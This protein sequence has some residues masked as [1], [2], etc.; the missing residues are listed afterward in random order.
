MV[1]NSKHEAAIP[2]PALEIF[3][4]LIGEWNVVAKHRLIPD[5]TLHGHTSFEWLEGGAF[6]IM[7]SDVE[8][9][10]VPTTI[11]IIGS[12]NVKQ[13]YYMLS[14]DER[15]VSRK[16]EMTLHDKVWKNWRNQTGFSQRFT[17]TF[18]DDG[19]TINGI[20]ELS[21]DDSTWKQDLE[22]TYTRVK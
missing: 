21:E 14:F 3:S 17:G 4:I 15:G 1:K 8:E 2:N 19:N 10:G 5:T 7:H 6:I 16:L 11:A 9:P 18:S 22:Q 20:W 13:E 12:D